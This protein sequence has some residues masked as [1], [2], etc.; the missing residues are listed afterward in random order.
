MKKTD[1]DDDGGGVECGDDDDDWKRQTKAHAWRRRQRRGSH[2]RWRWWGGSANTRWCADRQ[3]DEALQCG[4]EDAD[5]GLDDDWKIEE[6][7]TPK[8][9][10]DV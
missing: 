4:N 9:E 3:T 7:K 5:R 8:K 10:T 6:D 1:Y 2:N